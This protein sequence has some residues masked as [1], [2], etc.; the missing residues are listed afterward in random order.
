VK[1]K[2]VLFIIITLGLL[3]CEKANYSVNDTIN[4]G[5]GKVYQYDADMSIKFDSVIEDSRCPEG[6]ECIWA[7]LDIVQLDLSVDNHFTIFRLMDTG[8]FKQDTTI[9]GY[10]IGI[11]ALNPYPSLSSEFKKESYI[12]TLRIQ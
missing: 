5:L 2:L 12:V 9:S 11:V 3:A 10:K 7:G 1:I 4:I 6:A 8:G